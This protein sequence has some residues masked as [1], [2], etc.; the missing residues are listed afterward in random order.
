MAYL[1]DTCALSEFT[2]P[3]P[4]AS[5]DE[6]FASMPDGADFVSVLSLGELE[7]GIKKLAAGRRR[8]QLERWFGELRD[9]LEGRI[10]GIDEP[11]ALEW[12]RIAARAE[13]SGAPIPVVD[14]LLGATAIVH[15][16]SVVTRNAS[17]IARTGASIIDPW[18]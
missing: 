16:L 12:G 3:K 14:A 2:K 4:S 6:W 11:V 8:G 13:R 10:L 5:V 17:D 18:S 7:K 9:R 1:I 15:G